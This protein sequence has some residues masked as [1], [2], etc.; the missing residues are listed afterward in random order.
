MSPEQLSNILNTLAVLVIF[1]SG[2]TV[3]FGGGLLVTVISLTKSVR[4]DKALEQA[5]QKLYLSAPIGVQTVTKE[6]GQAFDQV[7]GLIDDITGGTGTA[8]ASVKA[9]TTTVSAPKS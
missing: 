6:V 7:G 3:V 8:S 5:I 4:N 1:L 2:T 9:V